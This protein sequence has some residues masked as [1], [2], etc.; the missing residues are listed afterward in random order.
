MYFTALNHL[1]ALIGCT[2]W[3]VWDIT[4]YMTAK[5]KGTTEIKTWRKYWAISLGSFIKVI[6]FGQVITLI[7]ENALDFYVGQDKEGREWIWDIYVDGEE[8][9]ALAIG[10]FRAMIFARLYN[11]G[12]KKLSA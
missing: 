12:H 8:L 4:S 9:I 2:C 11:V 1:F 6:F 3:I 7:Q 10:V 5:G